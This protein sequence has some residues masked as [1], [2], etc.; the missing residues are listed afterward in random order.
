MYLCL[1]LKATVGKRGTMVFT[2]ALSLFIIKKLPSGAEYGIN[3]TDAR[4]R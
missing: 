1:I 3:L 4:W 2:Q